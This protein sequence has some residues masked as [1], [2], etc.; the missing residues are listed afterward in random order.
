MVE[1][2]VVVELLSG[3]FARKAALFVQEANKFESEIFL[4]KDGKSVN[5]KSIMGVMSLAISP[6]QMVTIRAVGFDEATAVDK[7]V[8][9]VTAAH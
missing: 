4:E 7:L 1:K 9:F 6:A 2:Q 8:R 5:A 3:L